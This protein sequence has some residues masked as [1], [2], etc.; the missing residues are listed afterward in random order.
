[1]PEST[2]S[3]AGLLVREYGSA[4]PTLVLLH[5]GP[6]APGYLAPLARGLE[7]KFRVLE[8]FQRGSGC[9]P[10]SVARHVEDLRG[11]LDEREDCRAPALVGHS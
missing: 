5:G 11:L 2:R 6:G 3:A 10:L 1:M 7:D 4:G 9:V 8:P